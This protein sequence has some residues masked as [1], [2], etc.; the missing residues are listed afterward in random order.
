M[1]S[2]EFVT[3]THA[4][5]PGDEKATVR[6]VRE[7][8]GKMVV[9]ER[10]AI[11]KLTFEDLGRLKDGERNAGLVEALRVWINAGRPKDA[12]PRSPRIEGAVGENPP[13][14]KVRLETADKV[15]VSVR[16]GSADRGEMARV[17]VFR[18]LGAKGKAR[19]HLVPIYPHEI[20][21][22]ATY[23]RPPSRAIV[24]YKSDA[25]WTPVGGFEFLF[26]LYQNSLVEIGKPDGE[27]IRGYFKGVNRST[28]A[29]NIAH[30][31]NPLDAQTGIGS[32]TLISFQK[33]VVDRL[34][35]VSEVQR[36]TRTWHGAACT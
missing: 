16:D 1:D 8:D 30:H 10:K 27:V 34:G 12:P 25:E 28:A 7:R 2:L 29:I 21:D 13:V 22:Q 31:V 36:E 3:G 32:K 24:A 5:T 6:Q 19:F 20:A 11:E 23:P 18:E 9:Y 4:T 17:D 26:S 35:Q 15:A 14:R 33:L